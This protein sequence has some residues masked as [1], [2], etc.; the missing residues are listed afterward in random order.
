[1]RQLTFL[2]P[3]QF[4]WRDVPA[5]RL[6]SD[7]DAIVAPVAVARCDLDLYIALGV[8]RYPGPFAFGH[9]SIGRVVDAG[10]KAGVAP[11]DLV[12]TPFQLSCGRCNTC[13][14]GFTNACE[15]YPFGAAYGLKPTSKT[16]FGGALSDLMY[17]PY[18]DHMLVRLPDG[19]DPVAA[20]SVSDNIAD[21]W[22]AVAGPLKDRP[23]ADVLIVGGLA[24][25]VGLYAAGAAVALGASRTLYLDDNE[26]RRAAAARL[27]AET[28]PLA[29]GARDATGARFEI[30]VEAAGDPAALDFAVRACAANGVLTSVAI[31]L[32]DATP[33]PLTRAYYQGL[34]FHTSRVHSR[35]VFPDALACI[36]CGKLHPETVTHRICSFA[37]AADA[38]SDPGQ[39]I[40]FTP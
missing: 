35:A 10:D 29:L 28:A 34:T 27:G 13:R 36:A 32:G 3:G 39:K 2:A 30:V 25:S 24:Q 11:G 14:R 22:R 16:E 6:N 15:A 26:E 21:G 5:P 33:M 31:H 23:G 8:I 38:M 1:M 19:V 4:E 7:T 40:V 20:A 9:E 12:A 37:E 17:V 18:A